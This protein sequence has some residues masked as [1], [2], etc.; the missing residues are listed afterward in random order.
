MLCSSALI[1]GPPYTLHLRVRFFSSEPQSLRDELT[2]YLFVLQLKGDIQSGA[3]KCDTDLG[4]ELA[5]LC[6]QC[7]FLRLW[8]YAI[9]ENHKNSR[10][11]RISCIL[12]IIVIIRLLVILIIIV[13]IIFLYWCTRAMRAVQ[14]YHV[15]I[16]EICCHVLRASYS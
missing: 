9:F 14:S 8:E 1:V 6:L 10:L 11:R 16:Q 15:P 3:L 13:I 2:R 12:I 4:A 5:A 7:E